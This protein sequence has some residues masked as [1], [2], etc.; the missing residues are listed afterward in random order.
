ML[1]VLILAVI[2]VW[3]VLAVRSCL[4]RRGKGCDGCCGRC[5]QGC[6][7]DPRR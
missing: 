1:E 3:L 2:G 6:K 4:R 5:G 7:D